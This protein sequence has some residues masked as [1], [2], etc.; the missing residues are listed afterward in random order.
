MS[1]ANVTHDATVL[2]STQ[3]LHNEEEKNRT[4][5]GANVSPVLEILDGVDARMASHIANLQSLPGSSNSSTALP[6]ASAGGIHTEPTV[7]ATQAPLPRLPSSTA[8]SAATSP[9][10][11]YLSPSQD[12][13]SRAGEC[14]VESWRQ[15]EQ[16]K[17]EVVGNYHPPPP[18]PPPP[19][20]TASVKSNDTSAKRVSG[21]APARESSQ[22]S[23]YTLRESSSS[24][25]RRSTNEEATTA[26]K[27]QYRSEEVASARE[28]Q[29]EQLQEEEE[30]K[31]VEKEEDMWHRD[32]NHDRS[33]DAK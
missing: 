21:A 16:P 26:T 2:A 27:E 22:H 17:V 3:I 29:V 23:K 18:P 1:M 7:N 11:A 13:A 25:L 31:E 15:A 19:R 4:E 9:L 12:P 24:A 10:R 28:E 30:D 14:A 20:R 6:V 5:E 32:R 8:S 33:L